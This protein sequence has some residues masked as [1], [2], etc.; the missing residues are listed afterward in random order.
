M[1]IQKFEDVV[2]WQKSRIFV[3]GI[4]LSFRTCKDF[5]F[6]TQIERATVSVMNNIAEGFERRSDKAFANFLFI[7]KGSCAEVRSM[8]YI[9]S[10]LGYINNEQTRKLQDQASEIS[11]I[12]S[13][14]IK[15]L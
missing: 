2:G 14:L 7:A 15:S 10:G 6:K 5:S 9:A 4:Y 11:R 1:V 8:L 3:S 12:L 13:G